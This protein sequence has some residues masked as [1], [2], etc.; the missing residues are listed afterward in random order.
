MFTSVLENIICSEF[1]KNVGR[2]QEKNPEEY[3]MDITIALSIFF[4]HN[5]EGYRNLNIRIYAP[6]NYVAVLVKEDWTII[7]ED[8]ID[9][10]NDCLM[11]GKDYLQG[12]TGWLIATYH[13]SGWRSTLHEIL[14]AYRDRLA[15]IKDSY[16]YKK[17]E[18]LPAERLNFSD[19][20]S[21][22]IDKKECRWDREK[23]VQSPFPKLEK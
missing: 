8:D 4:D 18:L 17:T 16:W 9:R 6:H 22:G 11:P 10:E 1:E 13:D 2:F 20:I 7:S 19:F 5:E 23:I 3:A 12:D 14:F 15:I 21:H